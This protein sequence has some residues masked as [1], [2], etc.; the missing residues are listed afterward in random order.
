LFF[1]PDEGKALD[2]K[3]N[4]FAY[5][6][7]LNKD[8]RHFGY[9]IS[10]VGRTRFYR[11]DVGFDRRV[12]TNNINTFVRYNSEPKPKA[13][14][15][16]W[17]VYNAF[18]SN[19]DWQGNSQNF[20]NESQIQLTLP[21]QTFMGGGFDYGY[22]RLFEE[23]FGAKRKGDCVAQNN[24]T[25]A[26]TDSERST[27]NRGIY[28]FAGSTL[29]KK[30]N[31]NVFVNRVWNSFDLDF[32]ALPKFSR[33]SPSALSAAAAREAGLCEGAN[34]PPECNAPQD[35][36][37]G[38]FWHIDG[39]ITYQP[40][41]ALNA[42]LSFTK[43]RL[44]RY[45]TQRLAFDENILSLRTTYQFTRFLFA[46]GRVDFDSIAS[47][48]KG[49]FLFGW[50]PNPGTAFYV[51]YNDDLGRNAFNPFLGRVEPGFRRNG[52]TFFIKLSYLFRRS[53]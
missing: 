34:K 6:T 8:G 20:N 25:F 14:L 29:S 21:R 50:T 33:V 10:S 35:P 26:G 5:A 4:G 18:S 13:K 46:R 16:S 32:G 51:G 47:N 23:E 28:F 15:I 45:D 17:R 41:P 12:N 53:F 38:D 37:P 19:F 11:A 7:D 2:R 1:Y 27:P 40:M 24:C 31:F 22:E 43:E 30:Y 3:E 9:D 52:R 44:F 36:G 42:S 48:Y 39:S 49:Q